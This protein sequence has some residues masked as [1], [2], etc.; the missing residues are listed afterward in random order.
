[1]I[2]ASHELRTPLT[3]IK[4][5]VQL[6]QRKVGRYPDLV[7]E[8]H[9][10]NIIHHQSNRMNG[11]INEM[12]DVSRIESGQLRLN[13]SYNPDLV[14]LVRTVVEQQQVSNSH[15]QLTLKAPTQAIEATLDEGR[16]EQVLNN[17]IGNAIKYSPLDQPIKI[18]VQL[19][20]AAS[21]VTISVED[22]GIGI[23]PDQQTHLFDRFYRVRDSATNK[24]DGL[25]LGLYISH[26]IIT[27]HGGR[28][29][30]ESI[31][32]MGSTFCFT[33]PLKAVV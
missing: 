20:S 28:I 25:G 16:I 21:E 1:M 32:G 2:I 27:R 11:L 19:N 31:P 9:L 6:L 30:L 4:G 12:F 22:C 24:I 17:L 26:Q 15:H 13:Y 10:V 23:R 33:L 5:Y 29:W 14:G 3:S 8:L 7:T 18:C